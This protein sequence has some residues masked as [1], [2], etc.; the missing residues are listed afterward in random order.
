MRQG[1]LANH[2]SWLNT[3][4][5]AETQKLRGIHTPSLEITKTIDKLAGL[6][7]ILFFFLFLWSTGTERDIFAHAVPV[8]VQYFQVTAVKYFGTTEIPWI[9][10]YNSRLCQYLDQN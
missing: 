5:N 7:F 1:S 3:V 8:T 4:G 2:Y 9:V 10:P 6:R